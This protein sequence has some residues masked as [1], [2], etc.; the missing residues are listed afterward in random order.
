MAIRPDG[1]NFDERSSTG[2]EFKNNAPERNSPNEIN[3][4]P[5]SR[6]ADIARWRSRTFRLRARKQARPWLHATQRDLRPIPS[7]HSCRSHP[8]QQLEHGGEYQSIHRQ[9]RDEDPVAVANDVLG[10]RIRS[11]NCPHA[12]PGLRS[13]NQVIP[14]GM[15]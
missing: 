8:A 10:G 6:A 15:T 1:S 14:Q 2:G 11:G 4:C 9:A 13:R 5:L 3:R 7:A 12:W